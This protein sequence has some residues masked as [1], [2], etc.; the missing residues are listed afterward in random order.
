L[1][2]RD[3]SA[4]S[5][6]VFDYNEWSSP[7]LPGFLQGVV[8]AVILTLRGMREER[9]SDYLAAILLVCGSLFIGQWM[10]GFA[11][12]YDSHDWRTTLMFYIK[13]KHLVAFGPLIWLYFRS[14]TNTD[15]S[16]KRTYWLHFLPWAIVMLEPVGIA[17]YDWVYWRALLGEPFTH[18]FGT[19]GP[20]SEWGNNGGPGDWYFDSVII[21]SFLHLTAYLLRTI[22]EYR[23]Y[24]RYLLREFSNAEQLTF[25][26]LRL[27][28]YLM[29]GGLVLTSLLEVG[30][31]LYSETYIDSWDSYFAM[32]LFTFFVAIQFLVINPRLT[33]AL[34][35]NPDET[36]LADDATPPWRV[37]GTAP[38]ASLPVENGA[39]DPDISRW[40]TKLEDRLS[41]HEDHLN[42]DLK[43]GELADSIGTN[44]SVL[45]RV[46][47]TH[48]GKNF[49]DF[50]NGRRCEAFRARLRTGEHQ[51]HTL[52]SIALDCGFNS[53]STFN[54]A[55]RKYAGISPGQE[56]RNLEVGQES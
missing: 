10:F 36:R 5:D 17:L 54:R 7:L 1:Q 28:L 33:R 42:P 25:T 56:V 9:I 4:V 23:E 49:N 12:W 13:W 18:F 30:N 37:P 50:I 40:V 29:L 45:S 24:R 14:L 46:I 51:R 47:N 11:G 26:S 21:F 43:L 27:T 6:Y 22:R 2:L 31:E 20:A 44:S 48:Y 15:F 3:S 35:F 53:K 55:F 52:L 8:F 16:W 34:R 32:S 41:R 38:A 19:R 39:P